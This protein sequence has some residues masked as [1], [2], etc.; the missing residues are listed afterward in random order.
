MSTT[1]RGRYV[2]G[3]SRP[4]KLMQLAEGGGSI[5]WE[6]PSRVQAST[7]VPAFRDRASGG[8]EPYRKFFM[9]ADHEA[10]RPLWRTLR[11]KVDFARSGEQDAEHIPGFR[12]SKRCSHA[13]MDA[14]AEGHMAAW[15][16]SSEVDDLRMMKRGGITVGGTPE[17]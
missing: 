1:W 9:A 12:P 17:Q 8:Y 7:S 2:D 15:N 3:W 14:P 5:W 6:V 13:V 11:I 4:T 10:V 16:W